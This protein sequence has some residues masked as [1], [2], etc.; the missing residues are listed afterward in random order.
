MTYGDNDIPAH[1]VYSNSGRECAMIFFWQ[2]WLLT[3]HKTLRATHSNRCQC[4]FEIH[5][6]V[7]PSTKVHLHFFR[8][9]CFMWI[10]FSSLSILFSLSTRVRLRVWLAQDLRIV[11][12]GSNHVV[13]HGCKDHMN[14]LEIM[15]GLFTESLKFDRSKIPQ[16]IPWSKL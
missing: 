6:Q 4:Q 9:S 11:M 8:W 10:F 14:K 16:L 5:F 1:Y 12:Y 3:R 13:G 15:T 7:V 2:N